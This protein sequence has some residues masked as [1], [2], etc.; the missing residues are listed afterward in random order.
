LPAAPGDDRDVRLVVLAFL[1]AA[2]H[3]RAE[4]GDEKSAALGTSLSIGATLAG[5]GLV[6]TEESPGIVT[7]SALVLVGPSLG[8]W[9]AHDAWNAGTTA[10]TLSLAVG[11]LALVSARGSDSRG[12]EYVFWGAVGTYGLGTIYECATV[13]RAVRAYNR[14]HRSLGITPLVRDNAG[15]LALAGT[16]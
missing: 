13:P 5:V 16:F 6:A 1:L 12:P 8:H 10:R 3:A 2:S 11:F 4:D 9:Y 14:T 7:G 15:G